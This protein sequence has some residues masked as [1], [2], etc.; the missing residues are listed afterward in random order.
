MDRRTCLQVVALLVLMAV[1]SAA[2]ALVVGF[3]EEQGELHVLVGEE[4]IA[5]YVTED[6]VITRPF[7]AHLRAPGG[8]Q[9]TRNH[10]PLA[11]DS[12]DHSK[13]HPGLWLAFGDINGN[14]YWRLKAPVRH[15]GFAQEPWGEEGRGGFTVRNIYR[16]A[17]GDDIVCTERCRVTFLVRPSGVLV[18]WDS[19]LNGDDACFGD[20]EEMGLGVRLAT[21]IAEKSESGGRVLDSEGRQSAGDVWGKQ[22]AW[23]DYSGEMDGRRSG[24]TLMSHPE[25]FRQCWWHARD[26]GLLLANPFGRA[27]F[28]ASPASEVWVRE[29][30]PLRLRFGVLLH[31][32]PGDDCD[33]AAAYADYLDVAKEE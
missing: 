31:S 20:Q 14:D 22:A 21:P 33:P 30:E 24:I 12:D 6:A 29:G 25:N 27:A 1:G 23:C 17:E 26:Y 7:F 13:M 19:V 2:G 18:L 15:D 10:P 4:V 28:T 16:S 11:G 3:R 5:V 32:T 9:L 8:P